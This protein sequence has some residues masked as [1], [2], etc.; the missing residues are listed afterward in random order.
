MTNIAEKVILFLGPIESPIFKWLKNNGESII[1]TSDKITPAFITFNKVSFLISHGYCHILGKDILELLPD[2]AINLH[3]SY[4]PWNKGADPNFWSFVEDTP[5]G[6][7]IHYL[8][9]GV[10]TG[11]IIAQK[12]IEF[13]S[14]RET[15]ATSYEKLQTTIQVLFKENWQN[16]KDGNCQRK[17]QV[18]KGSTH[19]VKEKECLSHLL[20]HGW[21]TPVSVLEEYATK[22]QRPKPF[23]GNYNSEI[24]EIEKQNKK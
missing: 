8:D 11:D 15:L 22:T 21:N 23:C 20:T 10:D 14:D 19:R 9:E 16:I 18:I 3:I 5:K 2:R 12:E 13:D 7:T 6:C 4:L 1:Q 17:K 24:E